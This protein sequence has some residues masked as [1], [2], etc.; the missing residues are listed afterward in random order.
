MKRAILA[1][2]FALFAQLALSAGQGRAD[3]PEVVTDIAPVHS[4]VAMVMGEL[5]QPHLIVEPGSSP[6][7]LAL[8]PSQARSL[9]NADLVVWIGPELTPWLEKPVQSL[10][11][12]ARDL[13]LLAQN[14]AL[15]LDFDEDGNG[16]D[17]DAQ[18]TVDTRKTEETHEAHD[19][20]GVDPHAWLD[21]E[22]GVV[23][24]GLIADALAN[25]D[26]ENAQVYRGN[27]RDGMASIQAAQADVAAML[28][29][30]A[31][32]PFVTFHDAY[33]YFEHRF[34]LRSAG[35]VALGDAAGPGPARLDRLRGR[36]SGLGAIC[37]FSEPQFDPRLLDAVAPKGALRIAEVDPIGL[38]RQAGAGLYPGLIR[39]MGQTIAECLS[40]SA[41]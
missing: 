26:P 36:I 20:H 11:G 40:R 37:A 35:S 25:I 21:P 1:A 32:V 27:A 8:R 17:E 28:T 39:D 13:R 24:L 29:P 38:S 6:H 22:N 18:D 4:L 33:R 15:H 19:G 41:P 16:H 31:D 23:W 14:A 10:A 34:G 2:V 3:V 7:G 5:G 30:V 9:Q 12:Q